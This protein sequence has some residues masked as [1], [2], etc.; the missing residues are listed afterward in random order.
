MK[1]NLLAI[2]VVTLLCLFCFILG[3]TIT[4]PHAEATTETAEDETPACS[5]EELKDKKV[6]IFK[7]TCAIA[8]TEEQVSSLIQQAKDQLYT[9]STL[10][11][12]AETGR[13]FVDKETGI[14][15]V[16]R[17]NVD[18]QLYDGANIF[19]LNHSNFG[20]LKNNWPTPETMQPLKT[21]IVGDK[22]FNLYG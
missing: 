5:I 15:F 9:N 18:I 8:M 12:L 4:I 17:S 21:I 6:F 2:S 22:T 3:G 7:G 19:I 13:E 11:V 1:K 10:E 14:V 20:E 16:T